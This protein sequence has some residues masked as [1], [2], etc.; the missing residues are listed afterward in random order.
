M[1]SSHF[2]GWWIQR[3]V[4]F[5]A[6]KVPRRKEATAL[7]AVPSKAIWVVSPVAITTV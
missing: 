7:S 2:T 4:K 5:V 3:G 1:L 6:A